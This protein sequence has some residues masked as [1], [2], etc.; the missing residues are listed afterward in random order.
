MEKRRY[1]RANIIA[2]A[3]VSDNYKCCETDI[4][5]VS[6][7]GL[8]IDRVPN[9]LLK[10]LPKRFTVVVTH[11]DAT[12]KVTAVVKWY[13]KDA[14]LPYA[15]VG[16]SIDMLNSIWFNFIERTTG[17]IYSDKIEMTDV[18][19]SSDIKYLRDSVV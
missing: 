17:Y 14:A 4:I 7:T 8:A 19:G 13:K 3:S 1:K 11:K 10:D 16:L 12:A 15:T 5:D 2:S 6:L 18:W 9:A